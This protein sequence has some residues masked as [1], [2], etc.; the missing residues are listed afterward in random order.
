MSET[1]EEI[2]HDLFLLNILDESTPFSETTL[3]LLKEYV[4]AFFGIPIRTVQTP[5]T[6]VSPPG[7]SHLFE[8]LREQRQN[9]GGI[10]PFP[11]SS[12]VLAVYSGEFFE[13]DYELL[14]KD[15]APEER[16]FKY[17]V[18]SMPG[19]SILSLA[20]M[21]P[22]L[23]DKHEC[24]LRRPSIATPPDCL[25]VR[26][27]YRKYL[28]RLLKAVTHYLL[29]LL[30]F[31]GCQ[32]QRCLAYRQ[33]F[34]PD[35]HTLFLC[36]ECDIKFCR[37][38][39]ARKECRF[40]RIQ[41][42]E[43]G[44]SHGEVPPEGTSDE[45]L[46]RLFAEQ[47]YERLQ[48]VL[49]ECNRHLIP[50]QYE[51]RKHSEFERELEWLHYALKVFR[52]KNPERHEF[53]DKHGKDRVKRRTLDTLL[54][55]VFNDTPKIEVLHRTLEEPFLKYRSLADM[56]ELGPHQTPVAADDE[57]YCRV[58]YNRRHSTGGNYV[59]M[60]G[61]LKGKHIGNFPGIGIN[62]EVMKNAKPLFSNPR[63][64]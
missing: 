22:A 26:H 48:K 41:V 44:D 12:G 52:A 42:D 13:N 24:N 16:V 43:N 3:A 2:E 21:T 9:G 60:G 25:P 19:I 62:A 57:G 53:Y 56:K 49:K 37:R 38:M 50:V 4:L 11:E 40:F 47:R 54:H 63:K 33:P 23:F 61:T 64:D 18:C 58:Y 51:Y 59:E 1:E 45:E 46:A 15:P 6:P 31:E 29:R 39:A 20:H 36:C 32:D 55:T 5:K 10:G 27:Q 35:T 30:K 34:T 14:P 28:R 8:C 17:G 7:I